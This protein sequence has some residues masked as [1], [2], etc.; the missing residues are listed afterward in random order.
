MLS[1]ASVREPRQTPPARPGKTG[2]G[3]GVPSGTGTLLL[4]PSH[5]RKARR[6]AAVVALRFASLL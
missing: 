5:A 2:L 6:G 3:S 4:E 1:I